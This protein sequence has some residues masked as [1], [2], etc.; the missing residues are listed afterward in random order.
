MTLSVI[1]VLS[2]TKGFSPL[3]CTCTCSTPTQAIAVEV[4]SGQWLTHVGN[5]RSSATGA[6]FCFMPRAAH[7]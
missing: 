5:C 2:V 3:D 4:F 1:T 7:Q 6:P